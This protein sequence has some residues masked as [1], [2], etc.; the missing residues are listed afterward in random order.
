M[1]ILQLFQLILNNDTIL[2]QKKQ[3]CQSIIINFAKYNY[4][5]EYDYKLSRS[6]NPT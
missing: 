4:T 5:Y 3:L 1:I 6:R 2:L